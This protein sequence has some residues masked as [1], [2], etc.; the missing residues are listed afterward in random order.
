MAATARPRL[1][2]LRSVPSPSVTLSVSRSSPSSASASA[3]ASLY[4]AFA[5][6]ISA[7]SSVRR[8]AWG[9]LTSGK[10][11]LTRPA[12]SFFEGSAAI[13]VST[14]FARRTMSATKVSIAAAC[15]LDD[16]VRSAGQR[17]VGSVPTPFRVSAQKEWV[18]GL[19]AAYLLLYSFRL[20]ARAVVSVVGI[21]A[22]VCSNCVRCVM[23]SMDADVIV[24]SWL[25]AQ[26]GLVTLTSNMASCS[27]A[28]ASRF[29]C[30][31][32]SEPPL[33]APCAHSTAHLLT[34]AKSLG[35]LGWI[36]GVQRALLLAA[37]G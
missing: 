28:L 14:S 19:P 31:S 20:A 21:A 29:D 6:A 32:Y 8:V 35:Y 34:L 37:G 17:R 24:S 18:G 5:A 30:P 10:N 36:F 33:S 1:G 27:W 7:C 9:Q 16:R 12:L 13:S 23:Y 2:T 15:Q 26:S 11:Q 4:S 3:S 22:D 25:L